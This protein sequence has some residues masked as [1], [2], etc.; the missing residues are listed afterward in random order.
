MKEKTISCFDI[1][2]SIQHET[3]MFKASNKEKTHSENMYAQI[4]QEKCEIHTV[5]KRATATT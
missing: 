5:N 3:M 1:F 2:N 4:L